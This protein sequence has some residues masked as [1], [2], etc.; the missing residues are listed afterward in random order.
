MNEV[1]LQSML[2]TALKNVLQSVKNAKNGRYSEEFQRKVDANGKKGNFDNQISAAESLGNRFAMNPEAIWK[3]AN[4]YNVN[5][6]LS[7]YKIIKAGR[8]F[9]DAVVSGKPLEGV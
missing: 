3:W 6:T 5:L 1:L 4:K 8:G 2:K 9:V 7:G